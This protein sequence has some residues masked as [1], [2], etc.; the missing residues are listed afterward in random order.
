MF[1]SGHA[2]KKWLS[3]GGGNK[4]KKSGSSEIF[5]KNFEMAMKCWSLKGKKE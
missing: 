5:Y 2:K 3:G 1:G 4:Y